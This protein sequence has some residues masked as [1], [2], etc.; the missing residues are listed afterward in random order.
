MYTEI[1]QTLNYIAKHTDIVVLAFDENKKQIFGGKP[2]FDVQRVDFDFEE[3]TEDKESGYTFLRTSNKKARAV[4]AL[5]TTSESRNYIVL[6]RK[7]LSQGANKEVQ[8]TKK[9]FCKAAL[10]S[11]CGKNDISSFMNKY[12]LTGIPC[13]VLVIIPPV[14]GRGEDILNLVD[15]YSSNKSDI[16]LDMGNN[17]YVLIKFLDSK[18]D[19]EYQSSNEYASILNQSMFEELGITVKIGV[20]GTVGGFDES[21]L[22]FTQAQSAIK[23]SEE[24]NFKGDVFCYRDYV[25]I[26]ILY[27]L[28][29]AK[30]EEYNKLLSSEEAMSVFSDDEMVSTAEEFLENNLNVSETSRNLYMHRNTLMYRLDKIDRATGLNIKRFS[31]AVTFRLITII[32][33]LLAK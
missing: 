29:K 31:D 9:E 30:L 15:S 1:I 11:E 21:D 25:L 16:S 24:F 19:L 13:F 3:V 4:I 5:K 2:L 10:F 12:N 6:F 17:T 26:K 22:S 7:L 18:S 14:A 27:D 33:K 23:L 20:G 8:L 28:P 32:K